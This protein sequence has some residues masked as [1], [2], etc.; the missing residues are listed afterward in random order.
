[1]VQTQMFETI[2][3]SFPVLLRFE[4]QEIQISFQDSE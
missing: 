1:M 2:F 3:E 4:S